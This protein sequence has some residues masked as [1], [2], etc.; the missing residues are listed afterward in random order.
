LAGRRVF[1]SVK[2]NAEQSISYA[3]ATSKYHLGHDLP[4]SW[5]STA[6]GIEVKIGFYANFSTKTKTVLAKV[7]PSG[8]IPQLKVLFS[9]PS[10]SGASPLLEDVESTIKMIDNNDSDDLFA[11]LSTALG[12]VGVF[13]IP[14]LPLYDERYYGIRGGL[15]VD[16]FIL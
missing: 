14:A 1:R 3:L 13:E 2:G 11:Q 8:E 15:V 4:L 9:P 5:E 16:G 10:E 6:E 7:Y 12:Q